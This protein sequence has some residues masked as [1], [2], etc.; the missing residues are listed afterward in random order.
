MNKKKSL[1]IK[2][3]KIDFSKD[4][5]LPELNKED[6]DYLGIKN[7][8][9]LLKKKIIEL[10]KRAHP[11]ID[12]KDYAYLTGKALYDPEI[13]LSDRNKNDY[14]HFISEIDNGN[15]VCLIELSDRKENYEIVHIQK[16]RKRGVR[17]LRE[18]NKS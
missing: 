11:D 5:Y 16:M 17:R 8:P 2:S 9:V 6:L 7:K 12:E 1:K 4:N 10:N 13:I 3:V 18:K 14:H 15:S